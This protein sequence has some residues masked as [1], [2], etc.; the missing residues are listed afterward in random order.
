MEK[1]A[2]L[3][4]YRMVKLLVIKLTMIY[5]IINNPPPL[6]NYVFRSETE[7]QGKFRF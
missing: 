7:T 2:F 4:L 6:V 3:R 1:I 5:V